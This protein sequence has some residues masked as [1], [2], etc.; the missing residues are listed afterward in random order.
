[1]K[2]GNRWS[3][4][5]VPKISDPTAPPRELNIHEEDEAKIHDAIDE[6]DRSN[7]DTDS[8]YEVFN[9]WQTRKTLTSKRVFVST[10]IIVAAA[11]WVG[12]D[13]AE[14]SFFGLRVANGSP[15]R[16][17]VFVLL[18]IVASGIFYELSRRIDSSVRKA[19]IGRIINDLKS[20]IIPV[21]DID[22]AMRR[23]NVNSFVDLY[24]D[25]RSSMNSGQHH[26]IDVYRAVKFYRNNLSSA[27]VGLTLVTVA[28]HV[29]VYSIA[30]I[31]LI[32]LVK[33][34]TQ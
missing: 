12:I 22:E 23:N 26:A 10:S 32:A 21:A 14:L 27:G 25:F 29:I 34:L 18:S 11:G 6:L 7:L 2:I 1:M 5:S 3:G 19:R 30:A 28:E 17:L 24:F 31:A 13:Y 16:F 33:E 15:E 8:L 9:D 4:T 20:L